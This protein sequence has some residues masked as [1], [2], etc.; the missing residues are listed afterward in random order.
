MGSFLSAQSVPPE[1]RAT[2]LMRAKDLVSS[3]PVV[4]FSK[5][6][7]PYCIEVKRLLSSLK[8]K[9]KVIEL[10]RENDGSAVQSALLEW[11]GQRTVPNVFIGGKHIGGCDNTKAKHSEGKLVPLLEAAQAF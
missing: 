8:V 6:Y 7:C 9:M 11:T 4:V 1:V 2:A 10:D 3:N 5:S